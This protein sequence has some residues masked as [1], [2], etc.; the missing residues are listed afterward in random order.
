VH[1]PLQE[2]R[3]NGGSN[4]GAAAA[5][6]AAVTPLEAGAAGLPP[7]EA[8]AWAATTEGEAGREAEAAHAALVRV[9]EV[10]HDYLQSVAD[11]ST[12]YRLSRGDKRVF[13]L[14]GPRCEWAVEHLAI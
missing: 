10:R 5:S 13:A 1:R 12:I 6:T 2:Q 8:S 14:R 4:I 7:T 11:G 9:T 3:Q